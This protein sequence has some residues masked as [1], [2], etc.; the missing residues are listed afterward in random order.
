M[1]KWL[2]AVSAAGTALGLSGHANASG[3]STAR[4]TAEHGHP[5]TS[6]ATALYFN[7]GALV[8]STGTRLLLDGS[9]A[10]RWASFD[11]ERPEPAAGLPADALDEPA[12]GQGANYGKATLFNVFG[13][14]S[15]GFTMQ[16]DSLVW[17]VGVFAPFAGNAAWD[18]NDK[19]KGNTTYP[20]A[21]DGVAR[22]HNIEGELRSIYLTAGLAYAFGDFSVGVAGNLVQ[23]SIE[24]VRA[25]N[26]DGSDSLDT[27]GRSVFDVEGWHGSFA[28]GV[29]YSDQEKLWVG[30]SYQAQPGLGEM[31]MT[32]ELK[33]F[34]NGVRTEDNVDFYQSLPDIV[35]VGGRYRPTPELEVRLFGD[36][37]RWS[38]FDRQCLSRKNESCRVDS[39]G[40]FV[41]G[42]GVIQ[43]FARNWK[44]AFQVRLGASF[45]TSEELELFAGLGY[46]SDAVPD[47][48]LEPALMDGDDISV[49][50]G[51]RIALSD[52]LFIAGSYTHLYYF[53]RDNSG[54]SAVDS[55]NRVASGEQGVPSVAPDAGG[56]YTHQVGQL[57]ANLEVLF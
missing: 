25:R 42:S 4:F 23:S 21:V 38:V 44:D 1:R 52:S 30:A 53:P 32:G 15:L 36:Y 6:N 50:A 2:I 5:T 3:F 27:E 49:A 33:N 28:V 57:N 19:F 11:H 8:N 26:A 51:A 54:D 24:T 12:D 41:A 29:Q 20:G 31:K 37:T 7:P 17:G 35:R 55:P 39:R 46:D 22:W 34:L 10:L 45:W 40:A 47:K 18:T 14:P 43:N 9:L 48:Y 56:K 13:G 16:H